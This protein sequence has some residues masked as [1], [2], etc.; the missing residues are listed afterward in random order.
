MK[1]CIIMIIYWIIDNRN[2]FVAIY[3]TLKSYYKVLLKSMTPFYILRVYLKIKNV[4][5]MI[6]LYIL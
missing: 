3:P 4:E 2:I 1:T 5:S 6:K